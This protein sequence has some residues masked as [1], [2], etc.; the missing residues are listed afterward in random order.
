MSS[1]AAARCRRSRGIS[2][3]LVQVAQLAA[4]VS[5]AAIAS[6]DAGSEPQPGAEPAAGSL[7]VTVTG[8]PPD[9]VL[10]AEL[11]AVPDGVRSRRGR[12]PA[13]WETPVD[14]R[15]APVSGPEAELQFDALA[16]GRYAVRVFVDQN[17]NER[18]DANA[19]GIPEE[20]FGFSND[21]IAR[22]GPPRIEAAA[23]SHTDAGS[24]ISL[25]VRGAGSA[26]EPPT[27]DR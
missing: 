16:A 20:P 27:D 5:L 23:F 6:A 15:R 8:L 4:L 25:R 9:G 17:A 3:H 13:R 18:L 22:L 12:R 2:T 11:H 19:R 1:H 7:V 26:P 24:R 14:R 10:Y 21:A